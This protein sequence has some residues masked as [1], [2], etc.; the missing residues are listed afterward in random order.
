MCELL[1]LCFDQPVRPTVSFACLRPRSKENPDGWGVA[2]YPDDGPSALVLKQAKKAYR[3]PL[4]TVVKN[5]T[6]PRSRTH[7]IHIRKRGKAPASHANT[8]PF[9]R[10]I[11]RR[12][13]VFAHNGTLNTAALQLTDHQCLG[14][15]DSEHAF[16]FLLETE[17]EALEKANWGRL[18]D[19]MRRMNKHGTLNCLLSDG[20]FLAVYHD[21]NG[22]PGKDGKG[23]Y[24]VERTASARK[25][26]DKDIR[27]TINGEGK[28]AERGFVFATKPLSNE[29]WIS[30]SRGG[31]IVVE[32]GKMLWPTDGGRS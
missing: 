17:R 28:R 4:A 9:S 21:L 5:G 26:K 2:C 8:H 15:T 6:L 7:V 27:L 25:M 16:C 31:L 24:F 30:F 20:R 1:G 13:Y 18:L 10:I 22:H 32:N 23:L 29:K 3:N 14:R 12:E 19:T 11:G